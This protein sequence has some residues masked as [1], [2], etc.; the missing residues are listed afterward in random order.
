MTKA[1]ALGA[2]ASISK[3]IPPLKPPIN[4]YQKL[5]FRKAPAPIPYE[6]AN[7]QMELVF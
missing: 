4:L 3:A 5:G 2:P 6:R 1:R 7:I